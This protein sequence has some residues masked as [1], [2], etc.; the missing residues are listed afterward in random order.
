MVGDAALVPHV[1]SLTDLIGV[2]TPSRRS[3]AARVIQRAGLDPRLRAGRWRPA[4][5]P[6]A[7]GRQGRAAPSPGTSAT[8][9]WCLFAP[10][11][12]Q[13]PR[14]SPADRRQV[15]RS[16]GLQSRPVD[17]PRR[18]CRRYEKV[19]KNRNAL[20]R[21]IG[22]GKRSL[23][24]KQSGGPPGRVRPEARRARRRCSRPAR[25]RLPRRDSPAPSAPPSPSITQRR[26]GR[27][28]RRT[29]PAPSSTRPRSTSVP[30]AGAAALSRVRDRAAPEATSPAAPDLGGP[31]PRRPASSASTAHAAASL[32]VPG[33]A[34]RAWCWPGRRPRS[35]CSGCLRQV[36]G[37]EP[38][39]LLDDVSSELDATAQ[40]STCSSSSSAARRPVLHHDH[41]IPAMSC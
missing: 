26:P 27:R 20:L 41:R 3:I 8:S 17:Y 23:G 12:L 14:G 25:L 33:P 38:V 32:R 28:R 4:G 22:S 34:A 39:L 31:A 29:R 21:E 6:G 1:S 9:T 7:P 16:R 2:R 30:R 18:R 35:R 24:G 15:P 5:K 11:D 13:V 10:E 40:S 36:H 37:E 19:V